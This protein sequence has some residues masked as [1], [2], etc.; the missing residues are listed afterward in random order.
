VKRAKDL[1]AIKQI[2]SALAS[3]TFD[4]NQVLKYTMDMIREVMNVEAGSLLFFK[5]DELEVWVSFEIDVDTLKQFRLKLGQGIAGYTAA[6]GKSII[7]NNVEDSRHFLSDIDD[8]TGF[9]T[10]SA[11]C[12]PMISQGK[13]TGVIEVLNKIGGDFNEADEHLLQSIAS[14]VSIAIEN[15]RLYKET[16]TM[17][18]HERGIRNVFQKFVP[19]E[20]VDQIIHG[21][22][23]GEAV[24][25]EVK[26]LTL[27]NVDIRGFSVL[28]KEIGPQKAVS[29]L[30][31]FF[32]TMG[33]IVIEHGGIVDK[34]LGDGLLALF[35]APVSSIMDADNAVLA[36]LEMKK[37]IG[38]VNA[39]FVRELGTS[40]NIGISVH[41]GE[42]VVGNFGFERKMDYTVIGDAVNGVFRLQEF[43]K[44]F[45][46]GILISENT[47]RATRSPIDVR[48]T[49]GHC[50]VNGTAWEFEIYELL[51]R[52]R[53]NVL[54]V[55]VPLKCA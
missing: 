41:T 18:E 38:D 2:G 11:M 8:R 7:V 4:I 44:K 14:S 35:G 9:E 55:H 16:Q 6:R 20:I 10:R 43:T 39:H 46:N 51:G 49:G 25:E 36:A 13:V 33:N 1:D 54:D 15:A 37:A 40:V 47:L 29:L 45:P 27:L 23:T 31:Y 32:E 28:T 30:N 12:V 24:I 17:A 3:S 53:S 5:E 50:V 34:Y 52:K 42:V 48:D 22:E 21:S 26:T 19:K